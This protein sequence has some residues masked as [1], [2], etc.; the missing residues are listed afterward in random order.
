MLKKI[1]D[2]RL[3]FD[4][5]PRFLSVKELEKNISAID[6]TQIENIAKKLIANLMDQLNIDVIRTKTSEPPYTKEKGNT[7]FGAHEYDP[8][9][10][11]MKTLLP[12]VIK[13]ITDSFSIPS[14]FIKE[15]TTFSWKQLI[16]LHADKFLKQRVN[17]SLDRIMKDGKLNSAKLETSL[18]LNRKR[19]LDW[20]TLDFDQLSYLNGTLIG[21]N[22][23]TLKGFERSAQRKT[24]TL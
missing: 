21:F 20:D 15:G 16:D 8:S 19:T 6:A 18:Q 2:F 23:D 14:T 11:L 1:G 4:M 9:S 5:Q 22:A 13:K 10:Q 17:K 3:Q 12:P 24:I 7:A